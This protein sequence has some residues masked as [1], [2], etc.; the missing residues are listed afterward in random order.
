MPRAADYQAGLD[1]L[2]PVASGGYAEFRPG[3]AVIGMMLT[4]P[5]APS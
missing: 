1:P 3:R 5:P 4:T 2:L